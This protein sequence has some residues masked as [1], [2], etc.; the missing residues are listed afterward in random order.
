MLRTYLVLGAIEGKLDVLR[1]ECTDH[2]VYKLIE[3]Y[4]RIGKHY[5]VRCSSQPLRAGVP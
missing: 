5:G 1:V 2:H 4:G 3:K